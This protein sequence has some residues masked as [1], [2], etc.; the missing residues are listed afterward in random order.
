MK[1]YP[2]IMEKEEMR[3]IIGQYGH[4]GKQQVSLIWNL[5]DGQ[6]CQVCLAWLAMYN[7]RYCSWTSPPNHLDIETIDL[8]ADAINEFEYGMLLVS[9]DFRLSQQVAQEIWVFK[10]QKINKCTGDMA[11]KE[12][13]KSKLL[14]QEPQLTRRTHNV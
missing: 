4:T 11:F 7:T 3:K 6:K 2:E 9:H 10:R 8:L 13:L 1:C 14:G 12:Y 5:S